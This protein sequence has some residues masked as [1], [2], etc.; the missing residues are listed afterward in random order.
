M[1]LPDRVLQMAHHQ[2]GVVTRRALLEARV[3]SPQIRWRLGRT[4]R[5]ILPGVILLDWG[6]PDVEQ[7]RVAAL[8]YAGPRSWLSGLTAAALHGMVGTP[9]TERVDVLV[10]APQRPGCCD[11]WR[12]H[13]R[14]RADR[15]LG[16]RSSRRSGAVPAL[17][18]RQDA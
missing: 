11:G 9:Q 10:P 5:L 18:L 3:S 12:R 17:V 1:E 6:L 2:R 14:R 16:H 8:L 4:W 15:V 7:R 13:T